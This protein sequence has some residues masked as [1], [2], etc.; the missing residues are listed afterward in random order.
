VIRG[1]ERR[2]KAHAV[3]VRAGAGQVNSDASIWDALHYGE[4]RVAYVRGK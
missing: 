1:R 2:L 3:T 4:V